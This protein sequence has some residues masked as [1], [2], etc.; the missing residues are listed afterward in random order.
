MSQSESS[1]YFDDDPEF[2]KAL[3]DVE[4]PDSG[5]NRRTESVG[6][7]SER[8]NDHEDSDGD[9]MPPSTQPCLKRRRS[10]SDEE[11]EDNGPMHHHGLTPVDQSQHDTSYL[12]SNTYGAS[13]FGEFGEYMHRKRQKLQIQNTEM[14]EDGPNATGIF[15]GLQI[16]INGWTEPSVQELR[17]MILQHGGIFHAYLDRKSLVTHVLTCSL[18]PAKIREFKHMK[19]ATPNWLVKSVEAGVLLPWY[20]FKYEPTARSDATQGKKAPQRSL[21]NGFISQP[22]PQIPSTTESDVDTESA[23]FVA[24]TKQPPLPEIVAGPSSPSST[25]IVSVAGPSPS[26][27]TG[28]HM[29]ST[30]T[31]THP[32]RPLHTTDPASPEQAARVPGYAADKS[33][34]AAQRAMADPAWRAAN[35][36][37]AS[38][39]IEG[40][41]RNSRLH[42][43]STWKAELRSL[44]SEAQER[45]E[46]GSHSLDPTDSS[47]FSE[48][49]AV[50]KIVRENMDG[51]NWAVSGETED[52]SMKGVRLVKGKGKEKASDNGERVIMHCDFDSFFVSAGLVSRPHLRGKPVVVCHSQGAQGGQSSTSE[53]ASASYEARKFG[54]KSGMSL[55]QAR[56][57]CPTIQTVPYE[58]QLYKQ[59]SLQFYTIL[60]AHADDLQAVSVDE[61]L[62]DVTSSVRRITTQISLSQEKARDDAAVDDDP[63]KNFAEA[64]RAQVKSA[65]GCEVSIGV[66]QNVMLARLASRRAK[67]AGSFHLLPTDISAFMDTLDIDD[68]HGFGH[69]A[70]QKAEEKLGATS[71]RELAKKSKAVL[72]D[73]LG[74][75]TG[76]TLYKAMR[77]IDDK[78]IE[79]DKPRRSV[80]CDINYGIRFESNEQAEAFIYQ[81]SDEVSR[82]L[83]SISMCGRSLTLKVM[84]RDPSAPV[85]APKF[86]G[87]GLC[88]S[89][90]KQVAIIAPG[91]RA[92]N[93][94]KV[95]GAHAWRLL[96]GLG[97]DPK[98][99][100]GIGVQM[101]KLERI[102]VNVGAN[103]QEQAVLPFKPVT[104]PRKERPVDVAD[105]STRADAVDIDTRLVSKT[106]P[107][108]TSTRLREKP[109]A[110]AE[111]H[112]LPSF[113]Q[114]DMSVFE[115]LPEDVR[116][117][118]VTEY[119][120]RSVTPAI[121]EVAQDTNAEN[122]TNRARSASLFREPLPPAKKI[123]VK[124]TSN[125]NVKHITRQLAPKSRA[126]LSPTKTTLFNKRPPIIASA[127]SNSVKLKVS[128]DDLR[129][130]DIDPEVFAAL[131][132]ELQREQLALA[133]HTK[134]PV[135][136][137]TSYVAQRKVLKPR[138]HTRLVGT[139]GIVIPPPPPP[140]AHY[141]DPPTLKQRGKTKGEK[142][143]FSE[144]DDV[145]DVVETWF[146]AF[147]EKLPNAKDVEYFETWLV[148]CVDGSISTDSGLE[149]G[150]KVMKWWMVLLRREFGPSQAEQPTAANSLSSS[151]VPNPADVGR[152]WWSAFQGVKEKMDAAACAKFGGRLSL[153]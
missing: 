7:K 101:Q 24:E 55:Q 3:A 53:I 67:P 12:T 96:K 34:I 90:T 139:P 48:D 15:R 97:F 17:Q 99:L 32:S 5:S 136:G 122:Q 54:I 126:G 62:I 36:S 131:P 102:D 130:L 135:K 42:H 134:A 84:K 38:D 146:N 132:P 23:T 56:T 144:T 124:G 14:G 112:D 81:L 45:A 147:R 27:P 64:I 13:R 2:D 65:T 145:Q 21:Y 143:Y 16:Y 95:I 85:E 149:K 22:V 28:L 59:F 105:S 79:S 61:A 40:Y 20:E 142:L 98:E 119:R 31:V 73:A 107:T 121:G 76:E 68:L 11:E 51:K 91:G 80:S 93:D 127:V 72:C 52:V 111:V 114:V 18:T 138:K 82:R 83:R 10:E 26:T 151:D 109:P 86:M 133:K 140:K 25:R 35:T 113:S 6:H 9:N 118:L 33:N 120:R 152:A 44:V 4:I 29:L 103:D 148:R 77:G 1:D 63:A 69:A 104:S 100:R 71:L 60:M 116:A 137:A 58:F 141:P 37:V 46:N 117:E 39:F 94:P 75:G 110:I 57:L 70:H 19:V 47:L 89:F 66:A 8:N 49:M 123:V 92:T 50:Y 30:P 129:Q 87:H 74:K 43:L 78:K 41:Y 108:A 153:R 125:L 115:A 88:E 150:V 128:E 106:S